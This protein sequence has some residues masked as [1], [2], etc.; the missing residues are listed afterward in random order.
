MKLVQKY[1]IYGALALLTL[2]Q[3]FSSCLGGDDSDEKK[4]A[5]WNAVYT[6]YRD[7]LN[8][9]TATKTVAQ[10]EASVE[11]FGCNTKFLPEKP[12]QLTFYMNGD[13]RWYDPETVISPVY[14][15]AIFVVHTYAG[16]LEH[17]VDVKKLEVQFI[18]DSV[19]IAK[20]PKQASA[21]DKKSNA[22]YLAWSKKSIDDLN[23][24]KYRLDS[25]A[26]RNRA[27]WQAFKYIINKRQKQ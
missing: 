25:I 22:D 26:N 3:I 5:E 2:G 11:Q 24:Q 23:R 10:V 17:E 9:L 21:A 4:S 7:S 12:G 14:D 18:A 6:A 13:L 16:I 8:T 27:F 20:H 19:W 15:D 1:K